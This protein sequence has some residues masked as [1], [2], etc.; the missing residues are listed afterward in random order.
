MAIEYEFGVVRI[1]VS[2]L[3]DLACFWVSD[4]SQYPFDG[5]CH[6]L[7]TELRQQSCSGEIWKTVSTKKVI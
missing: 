1:Q 4:L 3:E 5:L 6:F 2:N 7:V